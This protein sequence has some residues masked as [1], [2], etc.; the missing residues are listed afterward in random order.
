MRTKMNLDVVAE[1]EEEKEIEDFLDLLH[2]SNEVQEFLETMRQE[3]KKRNVYKYRERIKDP[4]SAI[5]TYRINKKKLED[6]HDYVG[7]SFITNNEKEIYPIINYLKKELSNAEYIDFVDEECIYSPLVYIKWV[8][9]LGYNI[10]AKEKLIPN[11]REIPIEIRVCS[12]EGYVS[13]Q[14][15]YYSVQKNDMTNLPREEKNNLRNIVQHITY[16]LAILNMRELTDKEKTKHIQEL[17]NI[18]DRNSI[19]LKENYE[20]CKDGILDF[21]RLVYRCEHDKEMTEDQERL[22]K[23]E[24]DDIDE[25][26]KKKFNDFLENDGENIVEKVYK[27]VNQMRKIKYEEIKDELN[28]E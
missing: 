7:I 17:N 18:I 13:E 19:F 10:F 4:N 16:K 6:A 3:A 8:P 20:L 24:I 11:V 28:I 9:P 23:G 22:T 27:A 12:K 2:S 5:R 14:S 21:G 1:N 15:A 26:L 25:L